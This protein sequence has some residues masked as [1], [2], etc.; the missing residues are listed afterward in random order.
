MATS[1]ELWKEK[2]IHGTNC[3]VTIVDQLSPSFLFLNACFSVGEFYHS[4]RTYGV[5]LLDLLWKLM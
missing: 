4:Y 1:S 3:M 5:V 2:S